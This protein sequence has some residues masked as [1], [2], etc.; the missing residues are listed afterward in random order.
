MPIPRVPLILEIVATPTAAAFLGLHVGSKVN[1]GIWTAT[2]HTLTPHRIIHVTL[3]G[4]GVFNTQ[5][6]QDDIDRG[7]TGL[8]PRHAGTGPRA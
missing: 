8:P 5:V 1:I 7:N 4:V 3:V 2:Q 6:I